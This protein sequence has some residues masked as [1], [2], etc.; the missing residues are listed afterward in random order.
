[1]TGAAQTFDAVVI[2][3]PKKRVLVPLPFVPDDVWGTKFEHHVA[4]SVDGLDVQR[5]SSSSGTDMASCS[6]QRGAGIVT[7][8]LA[9][10]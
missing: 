5:W 4:G 3:G 10:P 2:V 6:A 8:G 7:S 1:M 9:I